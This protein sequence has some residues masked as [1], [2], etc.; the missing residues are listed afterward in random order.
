MRMEGFIAFVYGAFKRRRATRRTTHYDLISTPGASPP[1]PPQTRPGR[2]A[3]AE[4]RLTGDAYYSHSE[5]QQR[6]SQ[7]C[8]FVVRRSLA[9]ELHLLRGGGG[10]DGRDTPAAGEGR[11]V[12][13]SRRFSS[14]RVLGCV[15]DDDVR[16][17]AVLSGRH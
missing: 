1:P 7:S 16:E 12:S 5:S 17:S 8:R 2:P 3:A 11:R 15:I 10:D 9:D 6:Q 13:R 4:R 14:M